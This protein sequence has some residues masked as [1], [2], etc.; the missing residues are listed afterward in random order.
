[1]Y[2]NSV[3][4]SLSELYDPVNNKGQILLNNTNIL[5]Y[6]T[7]EIKS[8]KIFNLNNNKITNLATPVN[9]N[10]ASNKIYSDSILIDAKAY[11]DTKV[12]KYCLITQ[13]TLITQSITTS[14]TKINTTNGSLLTNNYTNST[15]TIDTTNGTIKINE[16]GYYDVTITFDYLVDVF[17]VLTLSFG[18]NN[19]NVLRKITN[20][21]SN[22]Y[23]TVQF[24]TIINVLSV[25]NLSLY[26]KRIENVISNITIENLTFKI[27]KL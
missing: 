26:L 15:Y 1:M 4:T 12:I 20:N 19:T 23:R 3:N 22:K 5:D 11:T 9:D 25:Y 14:M 10:D 13:N 8:Y 6:T 27:L 2:N 7:S 18:L 21:E 24:N 17:E 16:I